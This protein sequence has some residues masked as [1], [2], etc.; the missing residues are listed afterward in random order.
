LTAFAPT[1]TPTD[2][3]PSATPTQTLTLTPSITPTPTTIPTAT[4]TPTPTL[5]VQ[6]IQGSQNLLNVFDNLPA[7]SAPWDANQFFKVN[8]LNQ[9]YWR[10]GAEATGD[11][12]T[13]FLPI[14]AELLET[15][16]G[17]NAASRIRRVEVELT[18][19]TFNPAVIS[20][21][22]V[23]FGALLQDAS[24]ASKTVGVNVQ[25]VQPGVIKL[26]QRTGE[27]VTN[28]SNQ[29]VNVVVVRVRL[30]RDLKTGDITAYA[31]GAQLGQPMPFTRADAPILPVL[32]VKSGGVIVSVTGSGWVVTL[33]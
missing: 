1:G 9:T 33:R 28:F 27:K 31:N 15:A 30:E 22:Q 24:D 17:N 7:G 5:P 8:T 10:L 21:D 25:L 20:A 14:P 16:Y 32:F 4:N 6:G 3:P 2:V 18:L 29:A 26:G 19:T 12:D 23:Y 13:L 11:K